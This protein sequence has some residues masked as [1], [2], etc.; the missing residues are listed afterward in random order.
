VARS[1]IPGADVHDDTG[2]EV[3]TPVE[4]FRWEKALR[5]APVTR[6]Y[7]CTLLMLATYMDGDGT[8][9]RPGAKLLGASCGMDERTVRR[10]LDAGVSDGYLV[11]KTRGNRRGDGT[12]VAA[13]YHTS[14]PLSAEASTGLHGPV[15][16]ASQP[17]K[18]ATSTGQNGSSTGQQRPTTNPT[19]QPNNQRLGLIDEEHK[20]AAADGL[21]AYR[22][23]VGRE[24]S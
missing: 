18:P 6:N 10:H 8:S 23:A 4:R 20:A 15:E 17:G 24:A 16:N 21:R 13:E 19:N 14:L 3:E 5:E 9:G 7:L 12:G 1:S 2:P 22:E 11:R